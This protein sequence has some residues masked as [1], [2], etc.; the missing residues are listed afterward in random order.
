MGVKYVDKKN[1]TIRMV[2]VIAKGCMYYSK[3]MQSKSRG[4]K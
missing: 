1:G 2:V 3:L 4:L